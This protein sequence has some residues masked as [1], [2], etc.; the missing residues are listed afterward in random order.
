MFK[1]HR[2]VTHGC[3][4][5]EPMDFDQIE[6]NRRGIS[7]FVRPHVDLREPIYELGVYF[8]PAWPFFQVQDWRHL[9]R[10]A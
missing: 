9:D 1:T 2:E 10:P 5:P 7:L 3:G 8:K 4:G 6:I